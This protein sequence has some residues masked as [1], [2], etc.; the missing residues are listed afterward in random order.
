MSDSHI[1]KT[2]SKENSV[3]ESFWRW[4]FET[5]IW[6]YK[7]EMNHLKF[8]ALLDPY[9]PIHLACI[10]SSYAYDVQNSI[11]ESVSDVFNHRKMYIL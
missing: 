4:L 1:K 11:D 9:N 7:V 6:I 5:T 10:W 2:T 3:I 8:C